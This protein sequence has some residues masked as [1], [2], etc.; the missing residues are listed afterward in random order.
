MIVAFNPVSASVFLCT[1]GWNNCSG[2]KDTIFYQCKFVAA[3][4]QCIIIVVFWIVTLCIL[5]SQMLLK[6]GFNYH[7]SLFLQ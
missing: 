2:A 4:Q 6:C 3:L 1:P 7:I 5:L